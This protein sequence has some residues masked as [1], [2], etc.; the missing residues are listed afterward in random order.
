MSIVRGCK[1]STLMN[2]HKKSIYQGHFMCSW[3][4]YFTTNIPLANP[5]LKTSYIDVTVHDFDNLVKPKMLI[6]KWAKSRKYSQIRKKKDA[7]ELNPP[8]CLAPC[9]FL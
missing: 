9:S 5:N 2:E 7:L 4:A 6:R 8:K 1:I 3:K